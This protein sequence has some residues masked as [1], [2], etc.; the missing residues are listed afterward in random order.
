VDEDRTS[1]PFAALFALNMLV[2]T[3]AGDTYTESEVRGWMEGA[4]LSGITRTDTEYD[5]TLIVGR[6]AK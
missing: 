5:T 2:G 3:E 6:K 4:G 1:P